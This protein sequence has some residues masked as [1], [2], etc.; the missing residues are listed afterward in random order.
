MHAHLSQ[1]HQ[2]GEAH[3]TSQ[4]HPCADASEDALAVGGEGCAVSH[5]QLT[6][7]CPTSVGHI[8]ASVGLC[9]S[10]LPSRR[11]M[12]D[13]LMRAAAGVRAARSSQGLVS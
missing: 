3:R 7:S 8:A 5:S 1:W 11:M 2:H 12:M 10:L 4:S 6:T 9:S 13:E